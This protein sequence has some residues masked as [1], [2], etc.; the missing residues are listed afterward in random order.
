MKAM[1]S[2]SNIFNEAR[3]PLQ[4]PK[5]PKCHLLPTLPL[6]CFTPAHR[7]FLQA[8]RRRNIPDSAIQAPAT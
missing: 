3:F 5:C 8:G 4:L 1:T 2:V 7:Y 6:V